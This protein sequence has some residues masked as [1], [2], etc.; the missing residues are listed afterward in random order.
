M[1]K[2]INRWLIYSGLD[3]HI[4]ITLIFRG[5]VILAG[6]ITVFLLPFWINPVEQGYYLNFGSALALQVF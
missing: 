2:F 4:L 5:W 3:F 6:G 1:P